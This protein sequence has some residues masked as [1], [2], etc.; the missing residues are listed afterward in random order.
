MAQ[1]GVHACK[2]RRCRRRPW[3]GGGERENARQERKEQAK[4]RKKSSKGATCVAAQRGDNAQATSD[5]ADAHRP[6]GATTGAKTAT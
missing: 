6:G 1:T 5:E 3:G 4:R 2:R